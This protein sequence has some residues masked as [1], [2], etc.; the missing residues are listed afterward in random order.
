MNRSDGNGY[1]GWKYRK[2][3]K[4]ASL[5]QQGMGGP[6]HRGGFPAEMHGLRPPDYG[7]KEACGKKRQ[8]NPRKGLKLQDFC[9]IILLRDI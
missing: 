3:E 5:R 7:P 8:G 2:V 1:P 9:G 4:A 6:A